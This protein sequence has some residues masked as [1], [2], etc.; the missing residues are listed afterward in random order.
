VLAV[1]VLQV[2]PG[3]IAK[4]IFDT[5]TGAQTAILNLWWL[6]ALYASVELARL[7]ITLSAEW[8]G[9]TFRY[10]VGALLRRN[11]LASILRR[12][13]DNALPVSSGEAINRFRNDVAEV[14]DFPTWLP[15]IGGKVIAAAIAI[16][17]MARINLTITLVI[18]APLAYP[19][20]QPHE[21]PRYG[22]GDRVSRRGVWRGASSENRQCGSG[23]G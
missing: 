19:A 23:Y 9:W 2:V 6:I 18:F 4:T 8:S 15:D 21:R 22:R 1:F 5:L 13:G 16:L 7:V 12:P 14:G 20:L 11:L 17:V 10:V 3:L